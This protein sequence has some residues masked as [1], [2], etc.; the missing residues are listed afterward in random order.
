MFTLLQYGRQQQSLFI[1]W[2][3]LLGEC[4]VSKYK[5]TT[6]ANWY[7]KYFLFRWT[8]S[9]MSQYVLQQNKSDHQDAFRLQLLALWV[10]RQTSIKLEYNDFLGMSIRHY[11]L[12]FHLCKVQVHGRN[13]N[14]NTD[15]RFLV[16]IMSYRYCRT[17]PPPESGCSS[18]FSDQGGKRSGGVSSNLQHLPLVKLLQRWTTEREKRGR[19]M[20]WSAI[21]TSEW[22]IHVEFT[23]LCFDPVYQICWGETEA[24]GASES[25][26]FF[27]PSLFPFFSWRVQIM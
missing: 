7:E 27:F 11:V 20:K 26:L 9:E 16:E 15:V 23:Q 22:F 17:G 8:A 2:R 25:L 4:P 3:H 13:Y 5:N 21:N 1:I 10:G 14:I 18:S 6:A 19:N 12:F 24:A